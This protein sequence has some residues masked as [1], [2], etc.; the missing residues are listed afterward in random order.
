MKKTSG[1]KSTAILFFY[2][3]KSLLF[4]VCD[5]IKDYVIEGFILITLQFTLLTNQ[6][7]SFEPEIATLKRELMMRHKPTKK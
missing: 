4:I 2:E 6:C 1:T 3:K 7:S 5:I